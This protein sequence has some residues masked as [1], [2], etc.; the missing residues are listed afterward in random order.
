MALMNQEEV[1]SEKIEQWTL[2]LKYLG[3]HSQIDEVSS[4]KA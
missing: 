2:G 4:H 3:F 1:K